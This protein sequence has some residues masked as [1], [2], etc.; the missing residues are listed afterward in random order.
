MKKLFLS[1]LVLGLLWSNISY[2]NQYDPTNEWLVDKTVNQL[3]QEY[4]Y[5]LFSVTPSGSNT[6][7]YTLTYKKVVVSCVVAD[8]NPKMKFYCFLP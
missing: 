3:T 8:G 4:G 6:T 2:S 1:I 7:L 5:K